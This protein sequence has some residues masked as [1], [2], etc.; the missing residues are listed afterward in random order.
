MIP[1]LKGIIAHDYDTKLLG[2]DGEGV[3]AGWGI[4]PS[5]KMKPF[6]EDPR[7]APTYGWGNSPSPGRIPLWPMVGGTAQSQER[8]P[9][10][11]TWEAEWTRKSIYPSCGGWG[12]YQK[13][14]G[15][16]GRV[17]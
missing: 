10:P 4:R 2:E 16:D 1:R 15:Y 11:S 6:E 8:V 12:S 3:A 5:Q 13:P 17:F 7:D 9:R 14:W